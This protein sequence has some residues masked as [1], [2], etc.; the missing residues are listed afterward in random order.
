[1]VFS[2]VVKNQ[3]AG[4]TP[5][6]VIVGVGFS[7]DGTEVTWSDTDTTSLA[8]GATVSLTAN[9]GPYN[10]NTWTAI[11]GTHRVGAYVDDVNRISESNEN[12]NQLTASLTV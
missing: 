4:P 3:G 2:A 8:S 9:S 6:G 12:N 1:M 10:V 11:S 5:A 7:V